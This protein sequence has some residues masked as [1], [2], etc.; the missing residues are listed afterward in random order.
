MASKTVNEEP[1][2]VVKATV[3]SVCVDCP[4]CT[5]NVLV[6]ASDYE[7]DRL[8]SFTEYETQCDCCQSDFAFTLD[9]H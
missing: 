9:V 1:L 2:K 7:T 6:E 4:F 8:V 3:F 5:E